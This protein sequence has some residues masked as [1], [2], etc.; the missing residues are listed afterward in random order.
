[1]KQHFTAAVLWIVLLNQCVWGQTFR[2]ESSN[3]DRDLLVK[4]LESSK[5][6]ALR[7]AVVMIRQHPESSVNLLPVLAKR[8]SHPELTTTFRWLAG[9]N[10]DP[11]IRADLE[12][13]ATSVHPMTG[14]LIRNAISQ[15][16]KPRPIASPL[17][18]A[19][20]LKVV[21]P[22]QTTTPAT[23]PPASSPPA[24]SPPTDTE[25]QTNPSTASAVP[26][27]YSTTLPPRIPS[28]RTVRLQGLASQ[29]K[30]VDEILARDDSTPLRPQD[31]DFLLT[32]IDQ[33]INPQLAAR[34]PTQPSL[35]SSLFRALRDAIAKHYPEDRQRVFG[36]VL[37]PKTKNPDRV[38]MVLER[39]CEKDSETLQ[40]VWSLGASPNRELR[41]NAM[42]NIRFPRNNADQFVDEMIRRLSQDVSNIRDY[43]IAVHRLAQ[44][45]SDDSR[46]KLLRWQLQNFPAV[47][48]TT[49]STE[50]LH[51]AQIELV[52]QTVFV[53]RSMKPLAQYQMI[54]SI[55]QQAETSRYPMVYLRLL[56]VM[57]CDLDPAERFLRRLFD[58]TQSN[59]DRL[60]VA[61]VLCRAEAAGGPAQQ[62]FRQILQN[63]RSSSEE[64]NAALFGVY[65][66]GRSAAPL[67]PELVRILNSESLA[68]Q[69]SLCLSAIEKIGPPASP[70]SPALVQLLMNPRRSALH[71]EALNAL[72]ATDSTPIELLPILVKFAKGDG[73]PNNYSGMR[74]AAINMIGNYGPSAIGYLDDLKSL[75]NGSSRS[76]AAAAQQAID[77]IQSDVDASR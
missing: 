62:L 33:P 53:V 23:S 50:P 68:D 30:Q 38:F 60:A 71:R 48:A 37:D 12:Q 29:K 72:R 76:I 55:V 3:F 26:P 74:F 5:V 22:P 40:F 65:Q 34:G 66:M 63:P 59:T 69:H 36:F 44:S 45:I 61:K 67:V 41:K 56:T 14:Q 11:T 7:H 13:I 43:V 51:R 35:Y 15:Q 8:A 31:W 47:L 75:K 58:Q 18:T 21:P 17:R 6:E 49:R 28:H 20:P 10:I 54:D 32:A 1:M 4:L 25:P 64:I 16:T 57:R 24:T 27:K 19:S 39:I 46:R 2:Q 42:N 9:Q 73:S 70:A 52:Q 77:Q